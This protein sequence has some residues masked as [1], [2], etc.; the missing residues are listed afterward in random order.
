MCIRYSLHSVRFG[1]LLRCAHQRVVNTMKVYIET[2]N[3]QVQLRPF[4]KKNI[5][6]IDVGNVEVGKFRKQRV[7][8]NGTLTCRHCS[9]QTRPVEVCS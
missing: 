1:Q 2:K 7:Y 8:E 9:V 4:R 3:M 5:D 6:F